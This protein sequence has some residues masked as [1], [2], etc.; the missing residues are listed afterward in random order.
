MR[1]DET[2]AGDSSKRE[3]PCATQ[4]RHRPIDIYELPDCLPHTVV[5][6]GPAGL[7]VIKPL[8]LLVLDHADPAGQHEVIRDTTRL[9]EHPLARPES[10]LMPASHCP[11]MVV[12][13]LHETSIYFM[14]NFVF[15]S[16]EFL[17]IW[18]K[19]TMIARSSR[20]DH[21]EHGHNKELV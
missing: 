9:L 18:V 11:E 19:C 6:G 1:V 7:E 15:T 12:R 16:P 8:E 10:S 5:E 20:R 2:P 4:S 14:F 13:W 21:G 17:R 3:Y